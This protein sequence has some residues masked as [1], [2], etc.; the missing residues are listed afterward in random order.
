MTREGSSGADEDQVLLDYLGQ[1]L[2]EPGDLECSEAKP[3]SQGAEAADAEEPMNYPVAG[4]CGCL[5]NQTILLPVAQIVGMQ[6]LAGP[7]VAAEGVLGLS[8][9]RVNAHADLI[10]VDPSSDLEIKAP[11]YADSRWRGHML[12]LK[13]QNIGLLVNTISGPASVEE[14]QVA[15][16]LRI[17]TVATCLVLK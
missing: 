16:V 4:I 10:L 3:G 14:K 11:N 8:C 15:K 2:D 12:K 17:A 13:D 1:L 7:L 5:G 9:W 6:A